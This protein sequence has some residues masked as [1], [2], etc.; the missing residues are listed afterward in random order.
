MAN[1]PEALTRQLDAAKR[2]Y[3]RDKNLPPRRPARGNRHE[4]IVGCQASR[5]AI[6]GQGDNVIV[7]SITGM[8]KEFSDKPLSELKRIDFDDM[9]MPKTHKGYFVLARIIS[10]PMTMLGT[11][12]IIEDPSGRPEFFSI[13]NFPLR[14]VKTGADLDALFSLGQ[15]LAIR[16]PTYKPNQDGRGQLIRVD[17]P[18][19]LVF[20]QPDDILLKGV[21]WV[22]PSA[23]K[24]LPASFDYKAHGNSLFKAKKYIL[25]V[26]AYTDGLASA[27]SDKQKLLLHLNRAQ[28]HLQLDNFASAYR[29]S[30]AVLKLLEAGVAPQSQTQLKATLRRA[31]ALEGM[32][33][34]PSANEAYAA[35]LEVDS[36]S[37]EGKKSKERVEKMLKEADTGVFDW[38]ELDDTRRKEKGDAVVVV[39]DFVG[40]IKVEQLASRG[41]GRGVVA[42]KDIKPGEL[43]LVEKAFAVGRPGGEGPTIIAAANLHNNRAERP[44]DL[45]LASDLVKRLMDDP[46]TAPFLYSL[47]GGPEYSSAS[48]MSLGALT[49]RAVVDEPANVDIARLESISIQN[50]FGLGKESSDSVRGYKDSA[51]AL[52]LSASLFNHSCAPNALWTTYGDVIVIRSRTTIPAGA[53][54]FLAYVSAEASVTTRT[55]V[56]ETHFGKKGCSCELCK[57]ERSAMDKAT[58]E[59]LVVRARAVNDS[60]EPEQAQRRKMVRIVDKIEKTYSPTCSLTLRPEL[61]HPSHDLAEIIGHDKPADRREA[62]KYDLKALEAAG[63]VLDRSKNDI[64][65]LEGPVVAQDMAVPLLIACAARLA[66]NHSDKDDAGARLYVRAAIRMDHIIRGSDARRFAGKWSFMYGMFNLDWMC[67]L[68]FDNA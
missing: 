24:P 38:Q 42:T 31:R 61:V 23:A 52:F 34:L 51:S 33:L 21:K 20:L 8:P 47:Y 29:D 45:L 1:S 32:R 55:G 10:L 54:V 9:L 18:T 37:V 63:A 11:T 41:G 40:P 36:S 16:E 15:F 17:S 60:D 35:V 56:L 25:A 26:K 4:Y 30:S 49:S 59:D 22:F 6:M 19:D 27:T 46:S 7:T 12:M 2:A 13:Y 50:R 57:L 48:T 58:R 67:K 66:M 43:L 64:K 14:G 5:D 44:S 53:E 68:E 28:A 62:N 39:G 65:V 3:E